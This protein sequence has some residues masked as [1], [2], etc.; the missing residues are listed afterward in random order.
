[1]KLQ[2]TCNKDG[3]MSPSE[4]VMEIFHATGRRVTNQ[5]QLL[6]EVLTE[7][8]EHLDAEEIYALAKERDPNISLATVYRTLKVLKQ[9]GVV[10][11]RR[12]EL[13][14][15]KLRYELAAKAHYHFTC[16]GCGRVVE[17]E[18]PPIERASREL[19]EQLGL[20]LVQTRVYLDGYCPDCR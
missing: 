20:E 6:L 13:E 2:I 12:L 17:F 8:Q 15:Q 18:S 14:G 7:S 4:G 9:V 16:L 11:E 10:Q 3:C 1:M 19:A 5:R